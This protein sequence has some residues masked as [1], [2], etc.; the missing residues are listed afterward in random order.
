MTKVLC[1]ECGRRFFVSIYRRRLF[2]EVDYAVRGL[3]LR[4][5][6]H[7]EESAKCLMS[8]KLVAAGNSGSG[9]ERGRGDGRR[10]GR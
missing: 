10:K 9:R 5:Y 1:F 7:V 4:C 3:H 8:S 6:E 2:D